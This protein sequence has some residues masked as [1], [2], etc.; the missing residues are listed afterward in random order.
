M[1]IGFTS[2]TFRNIKDIEKIVKIAEKAGT[3]CIEWGGDIHIKTPS[4]AKRAAALCGDC[5]IEISSLGSYYKIGSGDTEKLK[6]T[7]ELAALLSAKDVRVWLGDKDSQ[8]TS[9]EDYDRLVTDGKLVCEEAA[10][11]GLN[12]CPEC[13]D[14]TFNNDTDAFLKIYKDINAENFGTYFQSRY[15][16]ERY[17]LDRIERTLPYIKS[18]HISFSEQTREQLFRRDTQ[19]IARLTE[20]LLS[21]GFSGNLLLEYTYLFSYAGIPHFMIND[22]QKLRKMTGEIK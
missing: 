8:K 13:H 20:K 6:K 17:D 21:C 18:V 1:N 4:D 7:L 22:I 11:L 10:K 5:G 2:T 15:K 16:K 12:I 14:G 9:K 3:D 19:Y